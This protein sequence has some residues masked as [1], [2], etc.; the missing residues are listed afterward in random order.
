MHTDCRIIVMARAPVA[1]AAKTRLIPV[2]GPEG[3]AQLQER[4]IRSALDGVVAAKLGSVTLACAPDF[5][6]PFFHRCAEEFGVALADQHG[7]DLGQRMAHALEGA[8]PALLIG[9]DCPALRLRDL[10]QAWDA[11]QFHDA[12]LTPAED[13]GYVLIGLQRF[14]AAVFA[15]VDWGGDKVLSQTRER[16]V[17]LGWRWDEMPAQ[18][19]VDRP[20]D[21]ER[22]RQSGLLELGDLATPHHE[23]G[24]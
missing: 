16:L 13:G 23:E 6:H 24:I 7:K 2:L 1:G 4:L 19:D 21:L 14:D 9:S 18:W 15:N 17:A 8:T 10:Q 12:V 11:L 20:E 22:L 5:R 3:A